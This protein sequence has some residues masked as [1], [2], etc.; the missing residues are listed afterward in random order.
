M[1]SIKSILLSL[2]LVVGLSAPSWASFPWSTTDPL[3][4][5][6]AT[7]TCTYTAT[8]LACIE[9]MT[10]NVSSVTLAGMTKGTY[11]TIVF[12]QDATGSRTLTQAS[13]TAA[14]GGLAV[15]AIPSAANKYTVWVILATS[16]SAATFVQ[17]YDNVPIW[18]TWN[19]ATGAA[20]ITT[21]GTQLTTGTMQAQPTLVVPGMG[22]GDSCTCVTQTLPATW[23]TGIISGCL[24]STNLVTCEEFNPT[25]GSITP[26][27]VTMN[28]RIFQ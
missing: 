11:Y 13:I 1:K 25:A 18:D 8:A 26:A 4:V 19:S 14:T 6:G 23:Q 15:P 9:N 16:A 20:T 12:V 17:N 5:S 24:P 27:A 10:A 21:N 7:P 3:E 22:A 28:V 2:A